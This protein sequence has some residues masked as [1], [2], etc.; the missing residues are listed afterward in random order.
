M[1]RSSAQARADALEREARELKAD[2]RAKKDRLREVRAEQARLL[3]SV[4]IRFTHTTR[5]QEARQSGNHNP[6]PQTED[7]STSARAA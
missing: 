4:G 5:S 2:M 7:R 6:S 1:D 3:A